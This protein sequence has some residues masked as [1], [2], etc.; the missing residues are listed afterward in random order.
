MKLPAMHEVQAQMGEWV[1][2][3]GAF[4]VVPKALA[5]ASGAVALADATLRNQP[6]P[7]APTPAW[8][9]ATIGAARLLRYESVPGVPPRDPILLCPSLINRLYILDL[10]ADISTVQQLRN[11]GHAVY[12]IDWGNP[13]PAEHG[14]GF[15]GFT[16]RL[17]SLL[18]R[19]CEDAGVGKMHV[20]GH[21]LGG[22]L[23]T[24]LAAVDDAHMQSLINLTVPLHFGDDSMLSKWIRA[25]FF[26]AQLV[27]DVVGH[28]PPW[29]TQPAF[30][31]LKPMGQASKVLRL[32]QSLD[33]PQF[34]EF[35]RCL[36]TWINDN[37]SIPDAF[38]VDLNERLYRKND[39]AGG[40]L[41]MPSI[42]AAPVHFENVR[43]PVMTIAAQE[44]HIVPV[45][46]AVPPHARFPHAGNRL[47]VLPG[48]HIGAVVGGLARKRLW[49]ALLEFMQQH[50]LPAAP[51]Q[52][53]KKPVRKRKTSTVRSS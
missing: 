30:Q 48:G 24:A 14:V 13:G 16:L 44:D 34:L 15:E 7:I 19:A 49:P 17:R 18:Q 32:L 11:D 37:V 26:D 21:C 25:P 42:A 33:K 31:V 12:G 23:A 50:A 36:E 5:R 10:K 51:S 3:S 46:S 43:I 1:L 28:V 22:T 20:L 6:A 52:P 40:R 2:R 9:I 45:A 41:T 27:V 39:L 4:S 35:F 47:E 38:F 29:L 53:A 8:C